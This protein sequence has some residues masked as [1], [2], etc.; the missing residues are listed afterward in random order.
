MAEQKIENL[1]FY[2]VDYA[3]RIVQNLTTGPEKVSGDDIAHLATRLLSVLHENGVYAYMLYVVWK[4]YN[5]TRIERRVTAQLDD[6]LV[7]EPG[8]YSLLRLD[9]VGLNLEKARDT[10]EA[11]K[12]LARD[13]EALFLAKELL[14][15]TL[16]Y[17]RYQAKA[18]A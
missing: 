18:A 12:A 13:L 3:Q 17:V 5:G 9:A 11:G 8:S 6:L 7:G 14:A 4:R 2:C 10:L 16:T 15:R 1:D